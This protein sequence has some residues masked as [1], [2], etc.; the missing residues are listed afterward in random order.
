M[1]KQYTLVPL[2]RQTSLHDFPASPFTVIK[3][4]KGGQCFWLQKS[5]TTTKR[6]REEKEKVKLC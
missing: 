3:A 6:K 5:Y 4:F 2:A 1:C